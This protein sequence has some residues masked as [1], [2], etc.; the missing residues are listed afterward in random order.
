MGSIPKF[1]EI[2]KIFTNENDAVEYLI[3]M[4]V[5]KLERQCVECGIWMKTTF[6]K[7][8]F[9][10]L[11]NG[12]AKNISIFEGTFLKHVHLKFFELLHFAYLWLANVTQ[13][14]ISLITGHGS[15]TISAYARHFNKL[16]ATDIEPYS[17]VIGGKDIIVEVDECKMGKRKYHRGHRVDG[18]WV[19]VGIERTEQRKMFAVQ[20]T[21]R[22]AETLNAII[23]EYVHD[24]SIVHTDCWR[25]Y[26]FMDSSE[27]LQ[28]RT[29]NHSVSFKDSETGVHTNTVEGTNNALKRA[30]P[31]RNRTE[32]DLGD[33]MMKFIWTRQNKSNLWMALLKAMA[34]VEYVE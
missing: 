16:V 21:D 32:K 15:A 13:T 30:V 9:R 2:A 1:T 5:I 12:L 14:S 34:S 26:R 27:N 31:V 33:S 7:R 8:R 24:G 4:R 20:V 23:D 18:A 11:C 28:H 3:D 22:N 17:C 29:V 25:G 19:V 10:H 6:Q